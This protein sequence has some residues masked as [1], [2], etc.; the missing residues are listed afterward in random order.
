MAGANYAVL[1]HSFAAIPNRTARDDNEID[2]LPL[3]DLRIPQPR[4]DNAKKRPMD[5]NLR[6]GKI[7]LIVGLVLVA[8]VSA[9]AQQ[10][11][12]IPSAQLI[13]PDELMKALQSPGSEKPLLIQV[14]SHVLYSQAHIPGSEYIGP[15]SSESGLQQLRKRVEPLPRNKF[16]VIYCGCC[17]WSHCPNVK[18]ANDALHAMGFT[19]VRVLY[20]AN[21]FGADWVDKNY[22]V[23]KGD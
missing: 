14:G 12:L 16:I 10:A 19:N 20:I 8:S 15:A 11:S 18:P 5:I 9:V 6:N 7:L 4:T 17:P 3:P 23:A 1:D 22:P 2:P 21:N 13:N